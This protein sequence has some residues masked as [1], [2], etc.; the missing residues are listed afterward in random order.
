MSSAR[1]S[2]STNAARRSDLR[3]PC[4]HG[5]TG[6]ERALCACIPC[7]SPARPEPI[8]G[9]GMSGETCRVVVRRMGQNR[10][11]LAD[12]MPGSFEARHFV[13]DYLAVRS[14]IAAVCGT[15]LRGRLVV[16]EQGADCQACVAT[17][18]AL[19]ALGEEQG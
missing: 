1:K 5:Y 12:V 18:A 13:T 14:P 11:H 7:S 15:T 2:E 17:A 10:R 8:G 6:G 16:M 19:A 4:E 9:A 3:P